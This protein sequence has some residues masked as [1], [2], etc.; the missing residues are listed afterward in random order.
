[1][2]FSINTQSV[3]GKT[4]FIKSFLTQNS[5]LSRILNLKRVIKFIIAVVCF[6]PKKRK[7]LWRRASNF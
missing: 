3:V 4:I 5:D 2:E 6:S 7:R 1:M